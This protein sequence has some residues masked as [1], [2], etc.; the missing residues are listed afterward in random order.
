[1]TFRTDW[2]M[3]F[4]TACV[5][6]GCFG[7]K[8]EWES[9]GT[10]G[11]LKRPITTPYDQGELDC[12]YNTSYEYSCGDG[13]YKSGGNAENITCTECPYLCD[14]YDTCMPGLTSYANTADE[15]ECHVIQAQLDGMIFEDITG[16]YIITDDCYWQN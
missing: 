11:K 7:D 16:T 15:T 2:Y 5:F 4:D 9:A 10:Y 6:C 12:V 8:G 3:P 14:K 1:M 13:F